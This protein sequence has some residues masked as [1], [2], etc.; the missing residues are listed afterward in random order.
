MGRLRL[1]S[2]IC[3][4]RCSHVLGSKQNLFCSTCVSIHFYAHAKIIAGHLKY[5]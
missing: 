1:S 2:F 4:K 5:L 3:G